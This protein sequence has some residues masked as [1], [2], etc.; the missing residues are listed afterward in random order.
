V[1]NGREHIIVLKEEIRKE[2]KCETLPDVEQLICEGVAG[3]I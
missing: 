3:Y 2:G 1:A